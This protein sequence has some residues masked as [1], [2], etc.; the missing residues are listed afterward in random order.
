L[1]E[2]HEKQFIFKIG[3]VELTPHAKEIDSYTLPEPIDIPGPPGNLRV[4]IQIEDREGNMSSIYT[5]YAIVH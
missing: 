2:R 4:D 5:L 1:T 3:P